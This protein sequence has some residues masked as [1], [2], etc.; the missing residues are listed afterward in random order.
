MNW[1]K[2]TINVLLSLEKN[3]FNSCEG[4]IGAYLDKEISQQI[5][6]W[7]KDNISTEDLSQDGRENETHITVV[8]GVC[9]DNEQ[10][11]KDLF[12]KEKPIKATLGKIGCFVKNDGFDVLL[13]RIESEDL[14]RIHKKI[15]NELNVKLTH[16]EYQPHCTIAYVKKGKARPLINDS[17]F[18]GKEIIFNK[19]IFKNSKNSK[20]TIIKLN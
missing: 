17:I 4:F 20:E 1:Y 6:Q 7:G 18:K 9:T 8:Y 11:V 19:I 16:D 2:K 5:Q 3:A 12:I 13:I 14:H 10:I 15:V